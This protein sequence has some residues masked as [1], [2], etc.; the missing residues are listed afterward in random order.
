MKAFFTLFLVISVTSCFAQYEDDEWDDYFMPGVG[1]KMYV[2]KNS[3]SL[4]V[5]QG[6]MTEFVIYSRA[7]GDSSYRT[8]PARVKTYGNLSII[9]SNK[10]GA[11]DIFFAN[12]GLN[13]SFEGHL[14]RKFL[15]PYFGLELGGMFQR[16]FSTFHF[17][18]V[19]GIQVVSNKKMIWSIQ[20]G[21]QYTT[22][23]F[24]ELSGFV[25]ASTFNVLLWNK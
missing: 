16:N 10:E 12:L 15:I 5:Y 22:K 19:A 7:K 3:D 8:G 24:D 1:Y 13:L 25:F 21:Y 14:K 11:K 17:S 23:L 2:P 20:G 18:P 4:G 6:V 9:A